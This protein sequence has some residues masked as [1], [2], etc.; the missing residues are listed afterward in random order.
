MAASR[1]QNARTCR[2]VVMCSAITPQVSCIGT[3]Q[4]CGLKKHSLRGYSYDA[5]RLDTGL[6]SAARIVRGP[7]YHFRWK[8]TM[9][10]L[11]EITFMSLDGVIDAP[12]LTTHAQRYFAGDAE[13]D[14]YQKEHLF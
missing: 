1:I 7:I 3:C 2:S 12:D 11:V 14:R 13:H 9:R 8:G 5:I 6:D 10:K 4:E